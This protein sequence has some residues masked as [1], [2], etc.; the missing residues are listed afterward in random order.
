[1]SLI[2]IVIILAGEALFLSFACFLIDLLD[3]ETGKI[4][5]ALIYLMFFARRLSIYIW[6]GRIAE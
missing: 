5:L 4:L 2:R 6:P 3:D 1:M